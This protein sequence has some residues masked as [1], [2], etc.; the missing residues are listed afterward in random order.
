VNKTQC[1]GQPASPIISWE[2]SFGSTLTGTWA[3]GWS[4]QGRTLD[5]LYDPAQPE[6]VE[7]A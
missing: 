2:W 7:L 5:V 4:W 3:P 1:F 6:R